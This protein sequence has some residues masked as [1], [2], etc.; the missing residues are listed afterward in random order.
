[1]HETVADES[2]ERGLDELLV[3]VVVDEL[4]WAL[5][6]SAIAPKSLP[7]GVPK[8]KVAADMELGNTSYWAYASSPDLD[9]DI[10]VMPAPAVCSVPPVSP[11]NWKTKEPADAETPVLQGFEQGFMLACAIGKP[12]AKGCAVFA[13]DTPKATAPYQVSPLLLVMTEIAS[14]ERGDA[15]MAYH[16]SMNWLPPM[17]KGDSLWMN[18]RPAVS[19]TENKELDGKQ[20]HPTII[21]SFGWVVVSIRLHDV[22]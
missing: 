19:L 3:E 11:P 1:L 20:S 22:A 16:V 7:W 6:T 13:P 5:M 4:D 2:S 21:T 12:E 18:V 9:A 8:D 17:L 15:E 14:E 10:R